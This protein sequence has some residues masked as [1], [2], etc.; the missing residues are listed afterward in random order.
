MSQTSHSSSSPA[1][2]RNTD[3]MKNCWRHNTKHSLVSRTCSKYQL[4]YLPCFVIIISVPMLWKDCQRSAFSRV[5]LMPLGWYGWANNDMLSFKLES[6]KWIKRIQHV[7]SSAAVLIEPGNGLLQ[8]EKPASTSEEAF[9]RI[10][11]SPQANKIWM[12]TLSV[13]VYPFFF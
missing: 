12:Y 13:R 9:H 5:T 2:V 3:V 10:N 11:S 8:H 7:N 1:V 4:H 6:W